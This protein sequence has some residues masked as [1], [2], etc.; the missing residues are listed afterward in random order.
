MMD[1]KDFLKK[2]NILAVV[3]ASPNTEK[4]GFK[5]YNTLKRLGFDVY[6]VNPKHEKIRG[7]VCYPDLKSLPKKPDVVITVVPPKITED[8]VKECRKIGIKKVWMQPGSESQNA[9]DFCKEN[10]IDVIYNVCFV[11]DGLKEKW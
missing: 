1:I 6:P 5:V 2:E 10:G 3:G 11:A 4:W 8:V 9:V 7:N